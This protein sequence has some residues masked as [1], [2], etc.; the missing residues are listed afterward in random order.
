MS[1][2]TTTPGRIVDTNSRVAALLRYAGLHP[3][4]VPGEGR[5][6]T[7][8]EAEAEVARRGLVITL[9]DPL[10]T[11]NAT[12][13]RGYVQ[14][15][16]KSG[17]HLMRL[18]AGSKT[19]IELAW[20]DS[21]PLTEDEAVDW[22]VRGN[23][24]GI[25]LLRSGTNGWLVLD[26][27][28]AAATELLKAAGFVPTAITANAQDPTNTKL[29]GCHV[30]LPLP[31]SV[32]SSTLKSTMQIP[33][34]G[35]GIVDVLIG[36]RYAV[37]PGTLLE[38]A[39]G[40]RYGFAP[41]G[42]VL[43]PD[44]WCVA[45]DWL[46]DRSAPAPDV[47]GIEALHGVA[48]KREHTKRTPDANSDRLTQEVDAISWDDWLRND[49]RVQILGVDGSCGCDWF[50]WAGAS[51]Q[52]SGILHDGCQYGFTMHSFS[53]T[54]IALLGGRD[55]MSRLA[56]AAFL[57][58]KSVADVA[59]SYGISMGAPLTGLT[60]DHIRALSEGQATPDLQV[61][62]GGADS[63]DSTG[64]RP[65]LSSVPRI[66]TATGS[67]VD[68]T[69]A[70]A[71][72]PAADPTADGEEAPQE[73]EVDT[74][75]ELF[76]QI[77]AVE[78][79]S[80]FWNSLPIL[81]KI[82]V[83]ADTNGVGRWGLLGATLPRI[84]C[85]VPPHVRLV[86]SAGAEGGQNSGASLNLNS[87][88]T[89]PP[90]EGKSETIKL[91]S[92][93]VQLPV[94]AMAITTGTGEGIIKSFAYTR[95]STAE[96]EK[97]AKGGAAP[98]DDPVPLAPLSNPPAGDAGNGGAAGAGAVLP[99]IGSPQGL[100]RIVGKGTGYERVDITDTVMLTA[101][102]IGGM[103]AE[104]GRQGTKMTS[105]LRSAWVGEELGTTA[106]EIERRTYLAPHSYRFG[107]ALG[108]QVDLDA[109][110]AIFDEGKLGS[111]QRFG[112]FPVT[113]TQAVGEPVRSISLTPIDWF[114]GQPAAAKVAG[115]VG[116]PPLPAWIHRPPAAHEEIEA[117]RQARRARQHLAYSIAEV[118]RRADDEEEFDD[119]RGHELLHQLKLAAV[120][121]IADGLRDPTDEYWHAARVIMQVR[122]LVVRVLMRVLNAQRE[123]ADRKKGRAQGRSMAE[124]RRA[125]QEAKRDH[126]IQ[127][128]NR[129]VEII[130]EKGAPA[131]EAEITR[132]LG[133]AQAAIA[134]DAL[135]EMVSAEIV[136][137]A[138]YNN[139]SKPLY[140][141]NK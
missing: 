38:A 53:G 140:W 98:V 122:D 14:C 51:T 105:V 16:L 6:V 55:T 32:D 76:D 72:D 18:R 74:G 39:P 84:A 70:L 46:L 117:N 101:G 25:N 12:E 104:M 43:D 93:L 8:A 89:G 35:G 134:T 3:T 139:R 66:G 102:E 62:P 128:A 22:L 137:I 73:P 29:G 24:P 83:A 106:G 56:F 2:N 67:M 23:N 92:D 116:A 27:E 30:W 94:H 13:A 113:T 123:V 78:V 108:A 47:P 9:P 1:Q 54:L 131:S 40:Y 88:L 63:T 11:L 44:V 26:A 100:D 87:I 59:A 129:I 96:K 37:A 28:N 49:P 57:R 109:L 19:P 136:F 81:R 114:D 118:R 90:E 7:M 52:R 119:I 112:F 4:D 132:K 107:S 71:P 130:R 5:L 135:T 33:L 111:P 36:A 58:G 79:A 127:V 75:I 120:L 141:I 34:E 65:A 60:R 48:A 133:K 77:A 80:G 69:Q 31:A 95:K 64:P 85:T 50:H 68:G 45:P 61:L 121:A 125:E 138:E 99:I 41:G 82:R 21:P 15:M 20:Q 115:M 110:G 126:V 86:N 103:T 42:G 97:D 17:A 10:P 124:A 91:A